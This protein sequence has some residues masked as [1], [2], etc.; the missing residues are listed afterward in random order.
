MI[1]D[2]GECHDQHC[3]P[4]TSSNYFPILL[5]LL[6]LILHRQAPLR[7]IFA[8]SSL[9][10]TPQMVDYWRKVMLASCKFENL[11]LDIPPPLVWD[12]LMRMF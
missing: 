11:H 10:R 3:F 6:R 4:V 2:L 7:F 12:T 8:R 9:T 1:L 5:S